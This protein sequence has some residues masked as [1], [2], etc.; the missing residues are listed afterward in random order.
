[1]GGQLLVR[2]DLVAPIEEVLTKHKA[3]GQARSVAVF[4]S[5]VAVG[6]SSGVCALLMPRSVRGEGASSG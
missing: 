4:R 5:V 2:A 1:M 3:T 6:T